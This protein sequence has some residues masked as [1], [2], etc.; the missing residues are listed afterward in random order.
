[1]MIEELNTRLEAHEKTTEEIR[2][3]KEA[4]DRQSAEF[5]QWMTVIKARLDA[6]AGKIERAKNN[7]K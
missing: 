3:R 2:E 4:I 5:N 1:M 6:I 7:T